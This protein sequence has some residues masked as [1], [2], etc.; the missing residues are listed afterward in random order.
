M[1]S[2]WILR[3]HCF[4]PTLY[5]FSFKRA[6]YCPW[7]CI[8]LPAPFTSPIAVPGEPCNQASFDL[9]FEINFKK[10]NQIFHFN[11]LHTS[12]VFPGWVLQNADTCLP[13][14]P[15]RP[16]THAPGLET[17]PVAD[18]GGPHETT[19]HIASAV[20]IPSRPHHMP[21]KFSTDQSQSAVVPPTPPPKDEETRS[22]TT[23]S[24]AD[25]GVSTPHVQSGVNLCPTQEHIMHG[26]T[27]GQSLDQSSFDSQT[28]S[29]SKPK[30]DHIQHTSSTDGTSNLS[31]TASK[32]TSSSTGSSQ[33][34]SSKPKLKDRLRGEVKVLT[35]K[36][37]HNDK[38]VQEGRRLLS[39]SGSH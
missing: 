35:G 36:M 12:S 28:E 8:N 5:P 38:L 13:D 16:T 2:P 37:K 19:T 32:G 22:P 4:A 10:V 27:I 30:L 34:D 21:Q 15:A 7:Q 14:A 3:A 11:L 26:K 24:S 25:G 23:E 17:G 39:G 6:F 18:D 9:I 31:T 1:P 33:S 20:S 29:E